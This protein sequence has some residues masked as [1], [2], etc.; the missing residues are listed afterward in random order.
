MRRIFYTGPLIHTISNIS[1]VYIT[2]NLWRKFKQPIYRLITLLS[3]MPKHV[4]TIFFFRL[5]QKECVSRF[6]TVKLFFSF[7]SNNILCENKNGRNLF[8]DLSKFL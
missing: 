5:M 3:E 2:L 8:V 6:S 1:A 4:G 7:S